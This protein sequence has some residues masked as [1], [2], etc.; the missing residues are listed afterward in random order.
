MQTHQQIPL[1]EICL[2]LEGF[3]FLSL[4]K[5]HLL[6]LINLTTE[7][8]KL[9]LKTNNWL[10]TILLVKSV[11]LLKEL[12]YHVVTME[13]LMTILFIE[14]Q[15]Q[16]YHK[17]KNLKFYMH[18]DLIQNLLRQLQLLMNSIKFCLFLLP[19]EQNVL[20]LKN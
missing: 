18:L 14:S 8:F 10:I 19:I 16:N 11:S 7:N 2:S 5:P 15:V 1:L 9:L 3:Q 20:N 17:L 13:D 4:Q 12:K 6:I